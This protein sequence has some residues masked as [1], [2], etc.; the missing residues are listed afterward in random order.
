M[1]GTGYMMYL[2]GDRMLMEQAWNTYG[3]GGTGLA[4][5]YEDI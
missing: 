1:H 5:F 3:T 2:A 4:N